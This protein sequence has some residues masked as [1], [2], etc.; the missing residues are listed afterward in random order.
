M[1]TVETFKSLNIV[2][3]L[4]LLEEY[5]NKSK[6]IA[7]GTDIV[8]ALRNNYINPEVMI[9]ISSLDEIRYIKEED[10]YIHLG[11]GCTYTDIVC[12]ELLDDRLNA[13]KK[14]SRLV[15]S[16]QIRNKGTIGGNIC[17][18]S[19]AADIVPPLLALDAVLTIKSSENTREVRLEDLFLGKGKVDLKPNELLVDI[20]FKKLAENQNLGF[21]KLGLRNALA[22]S[23]I[24]MSVYLDLDENDVIK[25][26][27]VAS[28]ALG[29]NGLRERPVEDNIKG[30]KLNEENIEI[31]TEKL[32]ELVEERLKGRSSLEYKSSAVRSLFKDAVNLASGKTLPQ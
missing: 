1:N 32:V 10:G 19:P 9:D 4:K 5:E 12:S 14:S 29:V 23:R 21:S 22:I 25:D 20:K 27:K 7:G 8:I 24:C 15:G 28:G 17:N 13:M 18:G 31:A 2:D 3:T 16:P 26:I 11:A 6:I 30:K